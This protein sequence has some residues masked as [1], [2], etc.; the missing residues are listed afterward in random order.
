MDL[1]DWPPRPL[2]LTAPALVTP[3][4]WGPVAY[5]ALLA[6][7]AIVPVW[8]E[9]AVPAGHHVQPA[10]RA[11]AL[12]PVVPP[13]CVVAR[14]SAAWV[15]TGGEPPARVAVLVAPRTRRPDPHPVR[16][17]H[18]APLPDA[19]LVLLGGV[20]VTTLERTAADVARWCGQEQAQA[21]LRAL[22]AAGLDV[23]GALRRL[24]AAPGRRGV[25]RAR[26]LL[27]ALAAG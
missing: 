3:D 26:A 12:R 10:D 22:L 11:R 15:H 17:V 25:P 24:D 23:G 2:T 20:R 7:K 4:T 16:L 9:L 6:E 8:G 5:R 19:D 1:P 21:L 18:E 27:G 14:T 13:R